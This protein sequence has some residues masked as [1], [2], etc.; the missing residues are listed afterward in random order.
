MVKRPAYRDSHFE[1][2]MDSKRRVSVPRDY[3]VE[4]ELST[5]E[6]EI[7]MGIAPNGA[8]ACLP[9]SLGAALRDR[10]SAWLGAGNPKLT[11]YRKILF[12]TAATATPDGNGRVVVPTQLCDLAGL[13]RAVA[14]VAE[15]LPW[16]E[17]W[18]AD[19][20]QAFK[21]S[22][23][24]APPVG[25]TWP[26]DVVRELMDAFNLA[27]SGLLQDPAVHEGSTR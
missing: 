11:G 21:Q 17:L 22:L 12:A 2:S 20:W 13:D 5:G 3:R 14:W 23:D 9:G 4:M 1:F 8:L 18:A 27:L 19:R 10:T 24:D 25:T 15:G 16:F 26:P 7:W 6:E